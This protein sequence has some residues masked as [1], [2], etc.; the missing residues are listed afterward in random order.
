[1]QFIPLKQHS[2][3]VKFHSQIKIKLEKGASNVTGILAFSKNKK[4]EFSATPQ[5]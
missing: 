3:S 4:E 2:A 5:T 1:M